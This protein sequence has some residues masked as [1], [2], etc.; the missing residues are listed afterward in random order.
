MEYEVRLE[1]VAARSLAVARGATVRAELGATIIK[2]LDQ[3]WPVLRAQQVPT[4]HNV[5]MYLDDLAH[6][7]AGVDVLSDFVETAE[8][9]HSA[10]PAGMVATVVYWGDY[11]QMAPAYAAL[12]S[13]CAQNGHRLAGP[14]W[15][16][17]GD[18]NA[19]P[20]RLRTDLYL[21]LND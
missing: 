1:E 19:D 18:W 10:T 21:L 5:V 16:V 12:R 14:S 15:E 4:G 17:Y 7:V 11:A 20:C 2:L 6:V 3:V 8:V 9:R 13:W